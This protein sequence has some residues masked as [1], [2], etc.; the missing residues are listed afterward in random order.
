MNTLSYINFAL[1]VVFTACFCYQAVYALV[2]LLGRKRT[3]PAQKLCRYAVL[4]AARNEQAVIGQLLDSIKQQDYPADLIHAFVVADNCT[5]NTAQ[6]AAVHGAKVYE[7]QNK[8]LVGKGYALSFLLEKLDEE[9][10]PGAFDGYFIFDADNLLDPSYI[11]EMNR[12]FSSGRRVVTSYRNSKNFGDNWITAGYSLYFLRESEYMNRSRDQLGI[13][14]MVSGTGFLFADSLLRENGGWN[15]HLLT[16][17]LEFTADMIA[18]GEKIAY[19]GNAVLYDEQPRSLRQSIAQRSRWIKGSFQVL[20]KYGGDLRRTLLSTGSFAC[21]DFLM[22]IF[23]MS[24]LTILFFFV[25]V[26][27]FVVGMATARQEMGTYFISVLTASLNA[28]LVLYAMGLMALITERKR[29]HCSRGKKIRYSFT[30][31]LFVFT[32]TVALVAALF[33]SGQWKPIRHCVPLSISDLNSS[34]KK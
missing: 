3:F 21:Y 30:F 9:Y 15:Y 34:S 24:V 1:A 16:E 4:I 6:V 8:E 32:F 7:R 22:G 12:V 28:Y 26:A 20:G 10:G 31:P 29:I 2:R 25:N 19:C 18:K 13:S 27:M 23:S 11:T 5:D 14:C 17:D 33:G